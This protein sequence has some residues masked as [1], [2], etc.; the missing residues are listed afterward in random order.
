[1]SGD[2]TPY[3]VPTLA[4]RGNEFAVV[5]MSRDGAPDVFDPR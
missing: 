3:L 4:L 5:S 2:V 1:M